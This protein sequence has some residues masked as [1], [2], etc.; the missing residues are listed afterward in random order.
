MDRRNV[1][2][3]AIIAILIGSVLA[4]VAFPIVHSQDKSFVIVHTNDTHCHYDDDGS[5]GFVSVA[6]IKDELSGVMPVFTVDAGDFLSGSAYG[7]VTKGESSVTIMNAVGYDLVVPG[8]HEFD[9]GM[10]VFLERTRQLDFPVICANLVYKD[11]GDP[12]FDEYRIIERGGVRVGF[13]GLLTE[14][15]E[16]TT[17]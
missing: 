17:K 14:E 13:F 10:D 11:T 3:I 8:N 1:S 12:V 4:A 15:T 9:Y 16:S 2:A 6:A 5:A 7:N